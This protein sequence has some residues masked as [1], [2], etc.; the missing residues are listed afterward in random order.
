MP[1]SVL[2]LLSQLTVSTDQKP[3]VS[4]ASLCRD[5]QRD[6]HAPLRSLSCD[7]VST[8]APR[9]LSPTAISGADTISNSAAETVSTT[10][11]A[12]G[13]TKAVTS[14]HLDANLAQNYAEQALVHRLH[15]HGKAS[16]PFDTGSKPP[17]AS[18]S[19]S[20]SCLP[21][22]PQ[23]GLEFWPGSSRLAAAAATHTD[24]NLEP[25]NSPAATAAAQPAVRP[26]Q[27][28]TQGAAA[29]P[30]L[31]TPKRGSSP[32]TAAEQPGF[33]S[34]QDS[35]HPAAAPPYGDANPDQTHAAS[36]P[37]SNSRDATTGL[38]P[39]ADTKQTSQNALPK[40]E[41]AARG[42][43][44][45]GAIFVSIAAY[46]D[47][48]CQWTIWDLFKQ[49]E[50]PDLV[51]VGVVWQIDAVEDASF[52]RVPGN[53]KRHSQVGCTAHSQQRCPNDQN[54]F[55]ELAYATLCYVTSRVAHHGP[56]CF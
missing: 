40:V 35:G 6:T 8:S 36:L 23:V 19:A 2:G 12:D 45:P 24:A 46:R 26:Q 9:G 7:A 44:K 5:S 38:C 28:N 55:A 11:N 18:A 39:A 15:T 20:S 51:T 13:N 27:G 43:G 30:S 32:K 21:A 42:L 31:A 4:G 16:T 56:H 47:P 49:A 10:S 22:A 54:M 33:N 53:L 37:Q 34:E 25:K 41:H 52:V 3:A 50:Q 29:L 1:A 14:K 17:A 48:E